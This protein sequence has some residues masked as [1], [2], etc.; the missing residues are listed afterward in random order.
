[1]SIATEK[2]PYAFA[3]L[4]EELSALVPG[5][6]LHVGYEGHIFVLIKTTETALTSG[7]HRFLVG[8]TSCN[9]LI[10]EATTGPTERVREHLSE[11]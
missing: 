10:H 3:A 5:K 6:P 4:S 7:R 11:K 8:C 9:R 1:M 2:D